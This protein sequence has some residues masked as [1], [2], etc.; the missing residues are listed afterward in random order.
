MVTEVQSSDDRQNSF[1]QCSTFDVHQFLFRFDWLLSK[2][3][4]ALT[5]DTYFL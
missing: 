4:A 1:I 5:P 3:A 2:P